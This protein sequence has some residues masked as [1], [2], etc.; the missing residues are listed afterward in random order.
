VR[1]TI[2]G[3]GG[4]RVPLVYQALLRDAGAGRVDEVVLFDSSPARL[5]VI[6]EVLRQQARDVERAPVVQIATDLA[7]AVR[8]ANFVF[9]AVRIGG[10]AG[11]IIDERV[12]IEQGVLGQETVGAG[13]IAYGLRTVPFAL[14]VARTVAE[15]APD[16]WLI[17]F[18]NPAGL[19]TEAMQAVLGDRVIGICDSPSGLARGVAGAVGAAPEVAVID[20]VGLNHLGWLRAISIDGT[21]RLPSLL[22]DPLALAGIEEGRLFGAEWLQALGSIPNE[23]LHYY[24]FARETRQAEQAAPRTRG[25]FLAAQQ[26]AF[27]E[28]AK[29]LSVDGASG[30]VLKLWQDVRAERD[31]TYLEQSRAIAGAGDREAQDLTGGGYEQIALR[32]MRAIGHDE[33]AELIVNVANRGLLAHLDDSAVIEVTCRVDSAGARALPID[34]LTEHQAGLVCAVKAVER[35]VI[36]AATTGSRRAAMRAFAEHPLIDSVKVARALLDEY[37]RQ[38][39]E[40]RYLAGRG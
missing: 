3:G 30:A 22:S 27:Y 35:S 8:G 40:L 2:L 7:D 25:E 5:A 4:F 11:R 6:A 38:H 28:K 32:L 33:P 17:N 31:A 9:A 23:Y 20:Y 29:V 1:L 12:A 36:E 21:D 19:V 16:A 24:Y 15:V 37:V 18:T 34:P 10:V 39:T 26:D 14:E 13:G